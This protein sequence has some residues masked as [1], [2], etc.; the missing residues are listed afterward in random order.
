MPNHIQ[1]VITLYDKSDTTETSLTQIMHNL[2]RN[3]AKHANKVLGRT[4]AFW[5]HESYDHFVRN[6]KELERIIKYMLYN[7]GKANLIDDSKNWK[8][9]YCTHEF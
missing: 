6:A 1:L 3:S 8:R 7:P 9:I 4:G 5:Q 2:E